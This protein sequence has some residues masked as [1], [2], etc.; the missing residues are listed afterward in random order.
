MNIFSPRTG[1]SDMNESYR[2]ASTSHG[3]VGEALAARIMHAE[4]YWD[5]DAFFS[6]VDRWMTEDDT[7]L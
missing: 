6:Y 2:R 5:H 7:E 1:A 3:W 4:K